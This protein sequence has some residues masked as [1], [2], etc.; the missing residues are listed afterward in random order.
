MESRPGLC[1]VDFSFPLRRSGVDLSRYGYGKYGKKGKK[2]KK[3]KKGRSQCKMQM[4]MQIQKR[5]N[6]PTLLSYVR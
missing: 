5:F 3:E 6:V 2:E 4:Q 1:P